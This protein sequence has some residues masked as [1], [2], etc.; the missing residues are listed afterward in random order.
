[1]WTH[2]CTLD[3]YWLPTST[4]SRQHRTAAGHQCAASSTLSITSMSKATVL[5]KSWSKVLLICLRRSIDWRTKRKKKA[6]EQ[7]LLQKSEA[8]API[9]ILIHI[10]IR[11]LYLSQIIPIVNCSVGTIQKEKDRRKNKQKQ[12]WKTSKF[13]SQHKD[14]LSFP[15]FFKPSNYHTIETLNC[16]PNESLL[17]EKKSDF[18]YYML[19]VTFQCVLSLWRWWRTQRSTWCPTSWCW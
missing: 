6:W 4:S 10:V 7:H 17:K 9:G 18:Y 2:W 3:R 14:E 11:K 8:L 1:M 16:G 12:K 13:T 5:S 19:L 15:M